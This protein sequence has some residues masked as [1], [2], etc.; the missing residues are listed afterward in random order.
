MRWPPTLVMDDASPENRAWV[1]NVS[2]IPGEV[3]KGAEVNSE[4]GGCKGVENR[5]EERDYCHLVGRT[6]PADIRVHQRIA[7]WVGSAR[8][9]VKSAVGGKLRSGT[10]WIE[11][12]AI[13]TK[14][15]GRG[16]EIPPN[17]VTLGVRS[18]EAG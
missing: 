8:I 11:R 7:N 1:V 12:L 4:S 6:Q 2:D 9:Q 13:E 17:L 18:K 14:T 5:K 16:A 10:N 15:R 3:L